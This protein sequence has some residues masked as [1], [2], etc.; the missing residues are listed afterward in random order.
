MARNGK[1]S[2]LS[3]RADGRLVRNSTTSKEMCNVNVDY[4]TRESCLRVW[5]VQCYLFSVSGKSEEALRYKTLFKSI[6]VR[7][8][9]RP[10]AYNKKVEQ[11]TAKLICFIILNFHPTAGL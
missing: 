5:E 10:S 1:F 9:A 11:V 3:G 6:Q 7:E 8:R 2:A 4:N